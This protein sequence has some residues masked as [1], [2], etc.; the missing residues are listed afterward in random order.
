MYGKLHLGAGPGEMVIPATLE[1]EAVDLPA[2]SLSGAEGGER[3]RERER[4]REKN[5]KASLGKFSTLF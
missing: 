2:Q 4:E 3:E 1:T 5:Y